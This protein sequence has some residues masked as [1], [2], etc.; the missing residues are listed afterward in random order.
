VNGQW[1]CAE[2]VSVEVLG[3]GTYQWQVQGPV[4]TLDPNVVL[5]LFPRGGSGFPVDTNELDVEFSRWGSLK[6]NIGNFTVWPFTAPATGP[7]KYSSTFPVTLDSTQLSTSRMTWSSG[8]VDF[9]FQAHGASAP[10]TWSLATTP[11]FQ[12]PQGPMAVRL[13]LWLFNGQAPTDG[14]PIEVVLTDFTFKPQGS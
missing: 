1:Y 10:T 7:A 14:K 13:N 5:G 4:G 2:L 11:V 3:F 12:V 6:N 9:S 8:S